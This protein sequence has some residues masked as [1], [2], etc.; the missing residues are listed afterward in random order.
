MEQ[1]HATLHLEQLDWPDSDRPHKFSEIETVE[2]KTFVGE[3]ILVDN[4]HFQKCR[5]KHCNFVYSGGPFA[6]SEC[7]VLDHTIF[8][9]TGSANRTM[10]LHEV[11]K[12]GFGKGL[13]PY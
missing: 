10:R 6:F 1:F 7:E 8:S 9:P 3:R 12:P 2:D 13:P 5:F 4:R 11:L